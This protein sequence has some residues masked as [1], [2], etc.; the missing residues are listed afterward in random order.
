MKKIK[1]L[2]LAAT[3]LLT[4]GAV[5]S[6]TEKEKPDDP[7]KELPK[8]TLG[9]HANYGAGAGYSAIERGY[10]KD[11]GLDVTGSVGTG[12]ALATRCTTND[13]QATFMGNGVAWNYFVKDPQ[14]Q[15]V[16]LDNLTNDDRLIASKTGKGKDLT[17]N[18]TLAEIGA[19]LRGS[20][21][22]ADLDKTPGD[23]VTTLFTQ[24]NKALTSDFV[25]Y[26]DAKGI[27][28]PTNLEFYDEKNFVDIT[29]AGNDNVTTQMASGN[30]DFC[31]TFAPTSTTM[32]K[33]TDK[34]TTVCTT[35]THWP[36][37]Y[38]PSTWAV[39]KTWM[40]SKPEEFKSFMRGLVRGMELRKNNEA[41][42]AKDVEKGTNGAWLA[43]NAATNIAIWL[44]VD[45]Q[46]NLIKDGNAKQYASNIYNS[47]LGNDKVQK[48]L[49]IAKVA[50]F[51]YL[52]EACEAVKKASK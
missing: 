8:I 52:K 4:V 46:L 20:K 48:D 15:L 18:S 51:S 49:D 16:A 28:Q 7:V 10:F 6:C 40:T 24:V 44:G 47:H 9:L 32:E 42:C 39:N 30:Y 34:Y 27:N 26:K 43:K 2:G 41:E 25:W 12:P 23:F 29:K 1:L 5:T 17:I 22:I 11:E 19:A 45:D 50:D 14:I 36:E 38:K 13:V 33:Q 3:M 35:K 21:L 31:V 37:I